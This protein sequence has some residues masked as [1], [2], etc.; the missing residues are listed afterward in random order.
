MT[1]LDPKTYANHLVFLLIIIIILDFFRGVDRIWPGGPKK[2]FNLPPP[3]QKKYCCCP[4]KSYFFALFLI[5]KA[6]QA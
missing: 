5:S 2:Y 3:T 6:Q 1:K 4:P